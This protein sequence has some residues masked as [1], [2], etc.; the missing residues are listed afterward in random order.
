[1][2]FALLPVNTRLLI[3][4]TRCLQALRSNK[5]WSRSGLRKAWK[6]PVADISRLMNIRFSEYFWVSVP[7]PI[8]GKRLSY[9]HSGCPTRLCGTRSEPVEVGLGNG[10]QLLFPLCASA[11]PLVFGGEQQ[12]PLSSSASKAHFTV[13]EQDDTLCHSGARQWTG[14]VNVTDERS[15]FF[16]T[17]SSAPFSL[18]GV[19]EPLQGTT[20]AG[21]TPKQIR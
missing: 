5:R 4:P 20:R 17:S 6:F 11:S 3:S 18:R 15:M 8:L 19:A 21:T 1:M 2:F 13:R 7:T 14:T 16:C 12:Q 9:G 10:I